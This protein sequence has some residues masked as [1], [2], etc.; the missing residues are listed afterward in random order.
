MSSYFFGGGGGKGRAN[1]FGEGG[2]VKN[3]GN[4]DNVIYDDPLCKKYAYFRLVISSQ[5]LMR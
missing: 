5:P 2:G 1:E 3:F 4:M